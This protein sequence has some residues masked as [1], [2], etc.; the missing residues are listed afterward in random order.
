MTNGFGEGMFI[1]DHEIRKRCGEKADAIIAV[2]DA[3]HATQK[4]MAT[5]PKGARSKA[6]VEKFLAAIPNDEPIAD[7][8]Q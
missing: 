8:S 7:E 6:N 3:D 2:L 1:Y 4:D 5:W